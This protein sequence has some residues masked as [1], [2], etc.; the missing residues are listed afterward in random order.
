MDTAKD[1]LSRIESLLQLAMR[2]HLAEL[3]WEEEGLRVNIRR[4]PMG[5]HAE[6]LP[7]VMPP[8]PPLQSA[9]AGATIQKQLIEIC[10]P[11]TGVFYR[12]ASPDASPYVDVGDHVQAG[13]IVCLIEAMKVYNEVPVEHSGRVVDICAEQ[14]QLVEQGT[15]LFRLEPVEEQNE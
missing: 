11:M 6:S 4:E 14:G 3:E 5:S 8:V 9:D 12:A 15:V 13:Q 2:F 1:E 7:L 10:A